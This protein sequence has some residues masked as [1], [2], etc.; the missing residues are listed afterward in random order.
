MKRKQKNPAPAG[1]TPNTKLQA[2]SAKS[3]A[4]AQGKPTMNAK[5]PTG[6]AKAGTT[7]DGKLP[8]GVAT[9][10]KAVT[11]S[12]D[13][14]KLKDK[15][16][17]GEETKHAAELTTAHPPTG[18][19][20]P[21]VGIGASAGGLAAFEAL[22]A[23]M[24]ADSGTGIAFV[25]VQHLD[26][27]HK[28]I[29]TELVRRYTKLRVFQVEDG[30]K[31]EPNCAY[32][33]RPN[34]DLMLTDSK[35]HLVEPGSR[36]GLRLP[37][38]FFFRSLAQERGEQSIGV[39]LSGNGTDGTLGL[40]AIKEAGGMAVVQDPQSAEYDGMPRSAIAS[41][42]AD[43]VLPPEEMP[44]QLIEYVKRTSPFKPGGPSPAPPDVSGWVLKI[45]ALLR[46]H[47]GH[48]FSHYKQ[49]TIRRRVERRMVVNQIDT[50]DHY[51]RVLRQNPAELD[52]LFRELLIGVT[53]FFR[54]IPAFEAVR[55][56]ALPAMMNERPQGSPIRIWV[57]GC[58]TGEEAYSLAMLIHEKAEK[59][60]HDF[61][62]TI[63]ATDIDHD[64]IE[65]ARAGLYP[66]SIA[67]D[68]APERLQRFFT[69]EDK[70]FYR[71]KKTLRDQLIFAEQDVIKD[72]PFS[73]LDLVSCRNMLIYMEPILQKRLLPLFHYALLP[74]GFLLLG[75]SES[76][77]E[78]TNLFTPVE[79]KWKLYRRKD[80]TI[81][82]LPMHQMSAPAERHQHALVSAINE[83]K[84]RKTSLREV[85][86]KLL[87]RNYA[88]AC[89]AVNEHGDILYIHGRSGKYLELPSGD[90][91]LNI[92]RAA[93]EG[94]KIELANGLRRVLAQRQPV[95]Y[96]N[97][98][99]RT[100]GGFEKVN[101][102]LELAEGAA[103]GMVVITFQ[104][105]SPRE[106]AKAAPDKA[107][108]R[109]RAPRAGSP[110]DEKDKHIANLERELRVKSETLQTT[111]EE[112]ETS[113]EELKSTNE[114]L[115]S[116]NEELQ[117]TNEELE[118]SKEELQSVNEELV[119]V[120]SELQ[121]KMEG[122]SRA[123]NDMNNLL[124]G[125]GIGML[126]VDH[127]LRI[128]R[129]TP[130]TTEII[131]LIQ[132]DIG[133][134]VSDLVSNLA[135]YDRLGHDVKAVLDTLIP[136]ETEVQTTNGHWYL[137]RILPYRTLENVIEGAVLTFVD[138]AAQ[139]KAEAQF[140]VL[141]SE[142][143]QRVK[144]RVAETEKVNEKL[145]REISHRQET[146][147]RRAT[148]IAALIHLHDMTRQRAGQDWRQK[149]FQAALDA[150]VEL[151][152][153]DMGTLQVYDEKSKSL[154][155]AAQSGFKLSVATQFTEVTDKSGTSCAEALRKGQR[156]LAE[157]VTQSDCFKNS[158]ALPILQGAGVRAV[159][160]TP[161]L[162][163]QGRVLGIFSTHW[164]QPHKPD[165]DTLRL[166]DLLARQ[167]ADLIEQPKMEDR[168]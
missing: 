25:I 26:P 36:R 135:S 82:M 112:L 77:G 76:V 138:I 160:S 158:P 88:P 57:P 121:Q 84:D 44:A 129:F 61:V 27:D 144:E 157:D 126:F 141:S 143:E 149:G 74:S 154:R 167:L 73:K 71:V 86:E 127:Q 105:P 95:R 29:L 106:P 168:R 38:D 65:K 79:R 89:V 80:L 10:I 83:G 59:I 85:T 101:V 128:Q 96:E 153:A 161:V 20:F 91:S 42:L 46:S 19:G 159:Q 107:Y 102:T 8:K 13:R 123:N 115:Q 16:G 150:A 54:D 15:A 165:E 37:I 34:K 3:G 51:V 145:Q 142:L 75:N 66:A 11:T 78:F 155:L 7:S 14:D 147:R 70:D 9:E 113:N 72:P 104:E 48:D 4:A 67:A 163:R 45:M 98:E 18:D 69:H 125:T 122:L 136:R 50:F 12:G 103:P 24:P 132:T 93:R 58:S 99:V 164:K 97:L 130:A 28:S 5:P 131:N 146:E 40:R 108:P 39:I 62:V 2:P 116:T 151:T 1:Q 137:M 68:V 118:T 55:D 94:L 87:L 17:D 52:I 120:N 6:P 110:P 33:I 31:I 134:P 148:D 114:E 22:F 41:G 133:R 32:I 90:A 30:M 64:S 109:E 56:L 49:N 53:G 156:V 63:F 47:T 35:L 166:L 23:H 119:T 152:R 92:V 162:S 43:Y 124:A 21:V 117:S 111:I 140:R 60:G 100:N 81:G 139:K